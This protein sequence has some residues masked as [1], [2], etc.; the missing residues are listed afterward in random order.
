MP[1]LLAILWVLTGC[2]ARVDI[3]PVDQFI[4]GSTMHTKMIDASKYAQQLLSDMYILMKANEGEKVPLCTA[5]KDS[6]QCIKEGVR[7]FVQG[8]IIPGMGKRTS[9]GFSNFMLGEGRLDFTKDN[10]GTTFIGTPMFTGSNS[11]RVYVK[12]GGLQVEMDRYYANWAG[13]GNMVMAEGWAIDYFDPGKGIIGLHL[14]L[15][16]AGI[17]TLGGG[18]SYVLLKFPRVPESLLHAEFKY[19]LPKSAPSINRSH[20]SE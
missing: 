6:R 10:S 11:C 19:D 4:V 16:I 18:S 20:I 7:V 17:L 2:V 3:P 15:D 5:S 9:Y 12:N 8:G 13:I 1:L 14:E